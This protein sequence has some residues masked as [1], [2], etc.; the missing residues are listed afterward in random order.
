MRGVKSVLR[1]LLA[2]LVGAAGVA[3]FV[4]P[5]FFVSIMP[6]A[7]P[8]HLELVYLSGVF[9]LLGAL[10][11]LIPA[12]RRAAAWGVLALFIAVYPANINHALHPETSATPDAAPWVL[13]L[14]VALQL[15]LFAWAYWMTRP[16]APEPS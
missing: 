13:W 1:V 15:L 14:R 10:G 2:A 7:L 6:A 12:T 3:H 8:W 11:L 5:G 9:E 16:D 4:T